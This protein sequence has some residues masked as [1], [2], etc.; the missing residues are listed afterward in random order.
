[1]EIA[2]LYLGAYL[3]GAVPTAYLL[4]RAVKGVD[5]RGY[6][7][8]NVGSANV[9]EHVGKKWVAPLVLFEFLIKGSGPVVVGL[10]V[11]DLDRSSLWLIG[12]ALLTLVGN[13]WSVFIRLQ[14]GRGIMVAGGI[15]LALSPVLMGACAVIAIGGWLV[16]KSSG[17]WVLI[18]LA[19][20]P[21]WA[22]LYH[23][24]LSLTWFCIGLLAVIVAKRLSSNW[25][26]LPSDVPKKRVLINRLF[27]DRDV[28]DRTQWVSRLPGAAG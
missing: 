26:P 12:A 1:M 9:F 19:L 16:T 13:N 21:V 23:D 17:P 15:L 10:Y 25:S 4:G 3:L 11:L 24:G 7:S 5:I 18:S 20:L 14:G 2:L 8:G 6:G 22:Y 27:R 28:A